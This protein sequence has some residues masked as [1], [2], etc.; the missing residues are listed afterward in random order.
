MAQRIVFSLRFVCISFSEFPSRFSDIR[1]RVY[2]C[3]LRL[4]ACKC[5]RVYDYRDNRTIIS[6]SLSVYLPIII[7]PT[8]RNQLP[9]LVQQ[10]TA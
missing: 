9:G 6:P 8:I 1:V 7:P 4:T 5:A 10:A 2:V 3:V